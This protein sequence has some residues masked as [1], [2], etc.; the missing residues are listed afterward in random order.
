STTDESDSKVSI[1][2][3]TGDILIDINDE[4]NGGSITFPPLAT[5]VNSSNKLYNLGNVL[6]WNNEPLTQSNTDNGWLISDQKLLLSDP[7]YL[8]GIGTQNPLQKLH[9]ENGKILVRGDDNWFPGVTIQ[10]EIGRSVLYLKGTTSASNSSSTQIKLADL[11]NGMTWDI[12]NKKNTFIL[13]S[14]SDGTDY[15]EAFKLEFGAPTNSLTINSNGDV[16]IGTWSN[17]HKLAVAGSIITEEVIVKLQSNWPDHVFNDDYQL[18]ELADVKQFIQ[19]NNHLEGIPSEN[20]LQNNG[21]NLANIQS[22]LLQKIEELTLYII[23]QDE[24]INKLKDELV[25]LRNKIGR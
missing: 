15:Q 4:T 12:L 19:E 24:D 10:N 3:S 5:I 18:P 16:G 17:E 11:A 22:K 21:I 6:Y 13:V 23:K 7:S 2:N 25:T 14:N 20:E 8:I 9:I 1:M